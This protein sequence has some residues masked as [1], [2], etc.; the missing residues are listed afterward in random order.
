MAMF[1]P[2]NHVSKGS[3]LKKHHKNDSQ[4]TNK[5]AK[6]E[7]KI[8]SDYSVMAP[9]MKIQS[10]LVNTKEVASSSMSVNSCP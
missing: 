6:M 10:Q 5:G 1:F 9:L 2:I 7:Q 8:Y 4:N 3:R